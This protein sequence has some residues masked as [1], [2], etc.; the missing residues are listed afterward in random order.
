MGASL[1][2]GYHENCILSERIIRNLSVASDQKPTQIVSR[3]KSNKRK[4]LLAHTTEVLI[5]LD[6]DV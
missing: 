4:C 2:A 3:K 5:W 1:E 6:K